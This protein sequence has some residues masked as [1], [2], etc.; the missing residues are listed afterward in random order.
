MVILRKKLFLKKIFNSEIAN[1][2]FSKFFKKLA[3][4]LE[5]K[6]DLLGVKIEENFWEAKFKF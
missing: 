3:S 2:I 4:G 1:V 5:A 6:I